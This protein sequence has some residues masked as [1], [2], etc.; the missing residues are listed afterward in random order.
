VWRLER[1]RFAISSISNNGV[2]MLDGEVNFWVE[3][4]FGQRYRAD[5]EP[6]RI[7]VEAAGPYRAVVKI[8][9]EFS[10]PLGRFFSYWLRLHFCAGGEQVLM[11]A[12]VRNRETGR[13]GR[14]LRRATLSGRLNLKNPV[15]RILHNVRTR[16]TLQVPLEVPE[17]IDIDV[18]ERECA[19]RNSASL[20]ED[21]DDVC[22]TLLQGTDIT[23][24]RNC[25]ALLDFH[26]PGRGGLLIKFAEPNPVLEAPMRLGGDNGSFEVDLFP[27]AAECYHFNEGMG[28]TRH[29]LFYTHDDSLTTADLFHDSDQ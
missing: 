11:L 29:L 15:H 28:K 23:T 26:Q 27:S 18:G 3:D 20:R 1:E 9:G 7:T 17:N 12:H 16:N 2:E 22:W 6:C 21:P 5:N 19:I 8:E 10:N 4:E 25:T 14:K 24:N 13:E